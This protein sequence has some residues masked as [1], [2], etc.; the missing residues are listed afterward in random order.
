[1]LLQ[2]SDSLDIS[3]TQ[4]FKPELWPFLGEVVSRDGVEVLPDP[5]LREALIRESVL[6]QQL[7]DPVARELPHIQDLQV[8]M[9]TSPNP[10]VEMD[11]INESR[12]L[13]KRELRELRGNNTNEQYF[14]RLENIVRE[15]ADKL[16]LLN[17]YYFTEN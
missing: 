7:S 9:S 14:A 5:R 3:R 4:S 17:K 8:R 16:P 1:M 13:V 12:E 11:L 15:N 2:S 6:L 10:Q